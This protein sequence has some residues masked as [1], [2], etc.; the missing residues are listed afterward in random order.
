MAVIQWTGL[1]TAMKGK[2][3]GSV[4][5][6]GSAGQVLRS[7]RSQNQYGNQRISGAQ[8]NQTNTVQ[9]W[10]GLSPADRLTWAAA[11]INF[12]TIDRFGNSHYPSPYTLYMRLNGALNYH[13]GTANTTAPSPQVFPSLGVVAATISSTPSVV[14]AWTY[15][16]LG[17][18]GFLM[19]VK[20]SSCISPGRT[21]TKGIYTFI[22][23]YD[24]DGL[25]GLDITT[26]FLARWGQV[27]PEASI[28]FSITLLSKVSGQMSPRYPCQAYS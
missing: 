14:L 25:T 6:G 8:L 18:S 2:L 28:C 17:P 23:R 3:K 24:V 7:N 1:T 13:T 5:Q 9:G 11:T 21:A 16:L 15:A 12:P 26:D 20:A 27:V 22:G 10:K 4:F 19:V